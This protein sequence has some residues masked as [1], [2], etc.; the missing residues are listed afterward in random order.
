MKSIWYKILLS[1]MILFLGSC[2]APFLSINKM[3][4]C[5]V[6]D[7]YS[8]FNDE[9]DF[10]VDII[11]EA[12]VGNTRYVLFKR[13]IENSK[14]T[15]HFLVF[16]NDKLKCFGSA[17]EFLRDDSPELN[18]IGMEARKIFNYYMEEGDLDGY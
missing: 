14:F 12:M 13:I 11:D 5:N 18:K 8:K 1:C 17:E 2:S 4:K 10:N 6:G 15:Y 9:S 16:E 3:G 7:S